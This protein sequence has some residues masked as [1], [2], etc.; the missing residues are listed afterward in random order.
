L[1]IVQHAWLNYLQMRINEVKNAGTSIPGKNQPAVPDSLN[2]PD[3]LQYRA[4]W[5]LERSMPDNAIRLLMRAIEILPG[6]T[7]E[8][9]H[10]RIELC[11]AFRQKQEYRK[12][13]SLIYG[14]LERSSPLSDKNLAYAWNRLA[15]LYNESG[16]PA[17]SYSDSV[18]KYSLL[19][20]EL[21]GR[22]GDKRD[23]ATSQNELSFQYIHHK[24]YDKALDLS[25]QSVSNFLAAGMLFQAMNSLINLSKLYVGKKD[26]NAALASLDEATRLSPLWENRNLYLRIFGQYAIVYS[27][28]GNFKDAMEFQNLCNLLLSAFYKDRMNSQILEQSAR[29]DLFIK[30]QKIREEQ[31]KNEFNHRQIIFLI[32]SCIALTLAFVFSIFYFRLRRHGAL[33]QKLIEAVVETENNERRRIARDLHDGLGPVLSAINHYFQ[34]FLDAKPENR[35]AIRDRLQMV[36]SE[37]ID[38]VSRISHNISPH[39]LE[40]H[41]LMTALNNLLAPMMAN[42][43]YEISFTSGFDERLDP[44]IEMTV[45]RC[46][47][48]LINNTLK[49]AEATRICLDIGRGDGKLTIRYSDNGKGFTASPG[50]RMGQGI[51]NITNRVE[52]FGGTLSVVSSP[53]AGISVDIIMPLLYGKNQIGDHR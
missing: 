28:T 25:R 15:A 48:E 8:A 34:A 17:G 3:S 10:F 53:N 51:P 30:E 40:K 31:K 43:T 41:G 35:E 7:A 46:I 33:K 42:E 47:T 9:D 1:S 12:G 11:E 26:Y 39:V 49:H 24:E 44:K 23:L 20:M 19:C 29:Y 21:S 27:A 45:Y 18:I 5:Y 22:I 36:I 13:I 32:I 16:N 38:E 50:K 14:L 37:A 6:N 2:H 4:R 52:S